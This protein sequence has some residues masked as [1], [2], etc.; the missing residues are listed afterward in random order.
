M[1]ETTSY[2]LPGARER[3]LADERKIVH[4]VTIAT[5]PD[6]IKQAPIYQELV[7]RGELVIL[8]HTGQHHDFRYSGGMEEEF[9][10]TVSVMLAINGS[11]HQKIAQMI[12]RFGQVLE[13]LKTAGKVAIPYIHGDTST[14]MAI[15]L[16]SYMHQVACVHVEAGIRTLTL[17]ADVYKRH[18]ADFLAG[19]FDFAS[20]YADSQ[21]DTNYERGSMEPFPEQFN[22]R[23]A[24]PATGVYAAPVEIDAE[25]LRQE[26][27][28]ADRIVVTGNSVADATALAIA[29][30]EQSTILEKYPQLANGKF[31]RFC[32]HRRENTGNRRRF[33]IIFEAMAKLIE[34]GHS[35]LLISLFGTEQAIDNY[36][37]RPRLEQLVKDYPESFIYSD[38]W[39]YYRDVIAAMRLAALVATDSGSMQEEM[40]ILG[41]P[42]VTLRFGSDRGETFIAGCNVAA[43]P[44]DTDWIV[45]IIEG[46]LAT[47]ALAK[48][49]NLYGENVSAKIVD[50]VLSKLTP[51]STAGL[52]QTEEDRLDWPQPTTAQ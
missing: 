10:L 25:F 18:Y 43:P 12:E 5:K 52:F 20:Y 36:G 35:V 34:S 11:L 39:P 29:D 26:G 49:P 47:P 9:G 3:L 44:V 51:G 6:I 21:I 15:G 13:E 17:K 42:C 1:N 14:A 22:T 23:V 46:A 24:E 4:I 33:M 2:F 8:C 41:I 31:I 32:I 38:V 16:S 45:A 40:N 27:F 37:L 48:R 50:L 28:S 19:R 7:R 30:S